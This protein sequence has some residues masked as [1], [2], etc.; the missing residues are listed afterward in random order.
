[1][2]VSVFVVV[3]AA[4]LS[5]VLSGASRS[6]GFYLVIGASA[7]KGF[8]PTG[9]MTPRGP[10]EAPTSRGYANDLDAMLAAKGEALTLENISCPGETIQTFVDG[11]DA[12]S[13]SLSL[14]DRAEKFLREHRG[15]RGVV[16]IDV[17]FNNVRPCLQFATV[18]E[19]CVAQSVALVKE[20]LPSALSSLEKAAG[21]QVMLV[22]VPYADPFLGHYVE[23][24]LG[25]TNA[26]AT[27]RAMQEM[28]AALDAVFKGSGIGVA[29][30]EADFRLNDTKLT[31]HY[32]GK[33]VPEDVAVACET[34]WECRRA[35]WGP[36]DHPDNAGYRAIAQAIAR[37]LASP[38][39]SIAANASR[40]P[41]RP[42]P[43]LAGMPTPS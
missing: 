1:M 22:G 16:T 20:D 17:G 13:P 37:A 28:D 18:D 40:A 36:N 26:Y 23:P 38:P 43:M 19:R 29:P 42:E 8:E 15:D 25:P 9:T 30:I 7:A 14:L 12:C 10:G 31:G 3:A 41:R 6:D 5:V 24:S 2:V 21:P 35:P 4:T 11:G 33:A 34:T 32:D 39:A 27:L